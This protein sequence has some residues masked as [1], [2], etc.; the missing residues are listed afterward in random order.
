MSEI[1]PPERERIPVSI[2]GPIWRSEIDCL[3][4]CK[5]AACCTAGTKLPLKQAGVEKME[6]AGTKLRRYEGDNAPSLG[7]PGFIRR[8]L[9]RVGLKELD[10]QPIFHEL[11]EDCANLFEISVGLLAC[12]VHGTDEQPDVCRNVSPGEITCVSARGRA[13]VDSPEQTSLFRQQIDA[14]L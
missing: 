10:E 12:K 8:F 9:A 11:V 7:E 1:D 2:E 3:K 4:N 6:R 13:G 5:V 14:D